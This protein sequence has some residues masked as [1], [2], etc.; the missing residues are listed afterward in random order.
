MSGWS[1]LQQ[2]VAS[3]VSSWYEGVASHSDVAD[4]PSRGDLS[5][6]DLKCQVNV[7]LDG[8]VQDLRKGHGKAGK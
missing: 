4:A 3:G 2:C 7:D 6:L 1:N 5:M 8:V